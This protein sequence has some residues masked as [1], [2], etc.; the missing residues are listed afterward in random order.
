MVDSEDT[1][2][3]ALVVMHMKMDVLEKVKKQKLAIVVLVRHGAHG[4]NGQNVTPIVDA[5]LLV[6][7]ENA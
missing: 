1:S 6:E 4:Q 7:A 3:Y 2:E 5:D